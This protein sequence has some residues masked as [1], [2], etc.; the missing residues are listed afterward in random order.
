MKSYETAVMSSSSI[1][2]TNGNNNDLSQATCGVFDVCRYPGVDVSD[3]GHHN[4]VIKTSSSNHFQKNVIEMSNAYIHHEKAE[5]RDSGFHTMTRYN[6]N[7]SSGE[8]E[9]FMRR[10]KSNASQTSAT[11]VVNPPQASSVVESAAETSNEST[12]LQRSSPLT[13]KFNEYVVKNEK[14]VIEI[15]AMKQAKKLFHSQGQ[16]KSDVMQHLCQTDEF[17]LLVA[18]KYMEMFN[19][20]HVSLDDSLRLLL[21]RLA[22]VGETQERERVLYQFTLHFSHCN[23][24]FL[25]KDTDAIHTVICATALLNTDLHGSK[26]SGRRRMS[27][28]QFLAN[29]SGLGPGGQD[30]DPNLLKEIYR[31]IK[32]KPLPWC[33]ADTSRSILGNTKSQTV[34]MNGSSHKPDKSKMVGRSQSMNPPTINKIRSRPI[35][36]EEVTNRRVGEGRSSK[37]KT[38]PRKQGVL[39][40]KCVI[41]SD[42]GKTSKRRRKWKLVVVALQGLELHLAKKDSSEANKVSLHHSTAEIEAQHQATKR[43]NVFRLILAD[44]S[45][46]L[47]QA[48]SF[49]EQ[50]LWVEAVNRNA[51]L[52]SAAPLSAGIGSQIKFQKPLLPSAPSTLPLP[53][54]LKQQQERLTSLRS[55]VENL[56][57]NPPE[58]GSSVAEKQ[59]HSDRYSYLTYEVHKYEVYTK[60]LEGL[61]DATKQMRSEERPHLHEEEEEQVSTDT[62]SLLSISPSEPGM[63]SLHAASASVEPERSGSYDGLDEKPSNHTK[64]TILASS[65]LSP[66][67]SLPNL[68]PMNVYR[69]PEQAPLCQYHGDAGRHRSHTASPASAEDDSSK[70]HQSNDSLD[71]SPTSSNSNNSNNRCGAAWSSRSASVPHINLL[72]TNPSQ[73]PIL[74]SFSKLNK[75]TVGFATTGRIADYKPGQRSNTPVNPISGSNVKGHS[76]GSKPVIMSTSYLSNT[77]SPLV[78]SGAQPAKS[79]LTPVTQPASPPALIRVRGRKE[80]KGASRYSYLQAVQDTNV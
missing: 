42:G 61:V 59:Y 22:L 31:S 52:L 14:R 26:H 78:E 35:F 79:M 57:K 15:R 63:S 45:A 37:M 36:H 41:D 27:S 8:S 19:L 72:E 28:K 13:P 43:A 75:T 5:R 62:R 7:T 49:E 21:K 71:S 80:R 74:T 25:S 16:D 60:S 65:P 55:D 48:S 23:P 53:Q 70:C 47:Y 58:N 18:K 44:G 17:G 20:S 77:M 24:G 34:R 46:C 64:Q 40:R 6:S 33:G 39:W 1:T 30:F 76:S 9:T 10:K 68:H 56:K 66:T 73:P 11:V 3:T 2:D 54:Q 32:K 12:A 69:F 38:L 29:L 67:S 4:Q 50:R 51:A